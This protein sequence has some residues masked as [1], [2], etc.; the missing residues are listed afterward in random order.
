MQTVNKSSSATFYHESPDMQT[1]SRKIP[2]KAVQSPEPTP[3]CKRC[4]L[5]TVKGIR[6]SF[7]RSGVALALTRQLPPPSLL[8]GLEASPGPLHQQVD[9]SNEA[10]GPLGELHGGYT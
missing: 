8:P 10:P 7:G 5:T 4:N 1:V 6:F 3:C 9:T 2:L